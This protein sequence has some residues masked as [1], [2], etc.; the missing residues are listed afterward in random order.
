[1]LFSFTGGRSHSARRYSSS[2]GVIGS[3]GFVGVTL[4]VWTCLTPDTRLSSLGIALPLKGP[5]D[6]AEFERTECPRGSSLLSGAL[7]LAGQWGLL[8]EGEWPEDSG[9]RKAQGYCG[10][11]RLLRC[12]VSLQYG[13]NI[14]VMVTLKEAHRK[15]NVHS[16]RISWGSLA[17]PLFTARTTTIILLSQ[18]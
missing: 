16:K 14:A 6:S 10:T 9:Y 13:V 4:L 17:E 5:R 12:S 8:W 1:M 11:E 15:N 2:T 7:A 18:L 3:R